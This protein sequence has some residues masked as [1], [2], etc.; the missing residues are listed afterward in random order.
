MLK[1]TTDKHEASRGL[2]ATAVTYFIP[3]CI[4]RPRRNIATP[5]DT[6]KHEWRDYP[7]GRSFD[8]IFSRFDRIPACDRQT[9]R[10]TDGRACE[11]QTSCHSIVRALHLFIHLFIHSFIHL[12]IYSCKL[13]K[14][15]NKTL[16]S[17][18]STMESTI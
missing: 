1:L 8:G 13:Y 11:R 16:L 12:F 4:R 9:D 6:E 15:A 18:V 17:N 3:S 5:F 2:S 14:I 7:M 10:R